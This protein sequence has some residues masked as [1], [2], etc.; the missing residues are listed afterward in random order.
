MK[1]LIIEDEIDLADSIEHYLSREGHL[2]EMA[3]NYELASEKIHLYEYDCILVDITL[4]DGNGLDIIEQLKQ[5]HSDVAII[6]ISAKNSINDKVHGLDIG[7][8]DYL[9]KPFHLSELN[10]R[11]KS[12]LRRIGF[13]GQNEFTYGKIKIRPDSH[14]V[15]V[16]D[17]LILLTPK[18]YDLLLYFIMNKNRVLT[19][20]AIIEH[21]W[22]DYMGIEADS[23]DCVYTHIRNLRKKLMEFDDTDH[24]KTVYGVGYKFILSE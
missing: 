14:L 1:I 24:I 19:K 17:H 8:D 2:C 7:A 21:L 4:P 22:G 10:S 23:L 3:H 6:I 11:I 18:E 16:D 9:A 13:K 20:E 12:I 15:Y 5:L